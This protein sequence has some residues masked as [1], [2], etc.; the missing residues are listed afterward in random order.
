MRSQAVAPRAFRIATAI[1]L[2]AL[3]GLDQTRYAFVAH[4]DNLASMQRAAALNP[5][6][7]SLEMRLA[8]KQAEAGH[9]DAATL[10]YEQAIATNLSDPSPRIAFLK[11]L[12]AHQRF[13]E[14]DI[15]ATQALAKWPTDPDLLVNHGI[16]AAYFSRSA[17]A[18]ANWEKAIAVDPA[19]NYAH[20]YLA[21]QLDSEQKF[22]AAI[23]HYMIFL[24]RAA[25]S[26]GAPDPNIVLPVLMRLADCN[27]RANHPERA[28]K[29][30]TLG[31]TI[32]SEA[33]QPRFESVASVN[34][35]I[36]ES[37]SGR[38]SNALALYQNA[39]KLDRAANDPAAEAA[40]WQAYAVFMN[41]QS[42]PKKLAYAALV[43]AHTLL[44]D[45]PIA[46]LPKTLQLREELEA[47]LG[48]A[49]AAIRKDQ[50]ALLEQALQLQ[51]KK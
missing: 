41:E 19:Q 28:L 4:S 8:K 32:A 27:L 22:E 49:S 46:P 16:L 2:L 7:A 30:Y 40:D 21:G 15:I 20:L 44:R 34:Q 39:L 29:L 9:P 26:G 5:F 51:S 24:E 38:V 10:A 23:P 43:R 48:M 33:H 11:Y 37:K 1:F 31:R 13:A 3:A 35:A 45:T 36:L 17:E 14:A 47:A 12:T 42:Y 18:Q 6:D 25:K 50:T